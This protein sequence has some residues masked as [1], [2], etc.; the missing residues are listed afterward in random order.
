MKNLRDLIPGMSGVNL[1][2]EVVQVSDSK[3]VV[4]RGVKREI[5]ELK[6]KDETGTI[7]LVLWDDRIIEDLEAGETLH[8]KNSFISSFRGDRRVNVGEY[9]DVERA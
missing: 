2:V 5:L 7:T 6:V 4:S 1:S 3:E 9:A 8:I